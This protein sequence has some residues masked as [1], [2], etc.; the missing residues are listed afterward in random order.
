MSGPVLVGFTV[1]N[2]G[3]VVEQGTHQELLDK[4]GLYH[5]MWVEQATHP[6]SEGDEEEAETDD[7]SQTSRVGA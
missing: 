1:L 3:Q 4:G 5:D 2:H 7:N 6:T